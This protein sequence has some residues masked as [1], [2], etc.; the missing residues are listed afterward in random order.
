M[1]ET[2]KIKLPE[3]S[4]GARCYMADFYEEG[5]EDFI[6]C[7]GPIEVAEIEMGEEGWGWVHGCQAHPVE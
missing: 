1:D 4:C 3:C 7:V 6:L 2:A 5:D